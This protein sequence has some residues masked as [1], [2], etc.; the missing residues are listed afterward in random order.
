MIQVTHL[1]EKEHLK[2]KRELVDQIYS[3]SFRNGRERGGSHYINIL[4]YFKH[5]KTIDD[6]EGRYVM[7]IGTTEGSKITMFNNYA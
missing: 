3:Y 6:K 4:S 2:L 5:E 1:S 7:F